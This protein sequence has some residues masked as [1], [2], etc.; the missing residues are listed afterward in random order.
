MYDAYLQSLCRMY[1]RRLR[2]YAEKRGLG[3]FRKELLRANRRRECEATRSEVEMLSRMCDDE[4]M[5]RS[6]IPKVLGKS[7]RRAYED[8]DFER[9]GT[10]RRL[11][12]YSKVSVLLFAER[13]RRLCKK[14]K[15]DTKTKDYGKD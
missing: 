2:Y 9:I 11:G 13:M 10:L 15:T 4:R 3:G 5:S 8:G 12:T 14:D 6:D 7:Y 1:L